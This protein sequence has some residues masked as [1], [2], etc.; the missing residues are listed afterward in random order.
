VTNLPD[1]CWVTRLVLKNEHMTAKYTFHKPVNSD[2][3]TM[4]ALLRQWDILMSSEPSS[5]QSA[6]VE[7]GE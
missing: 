6:T 2:S 3:P 1:N 5:L 7:W 4:D